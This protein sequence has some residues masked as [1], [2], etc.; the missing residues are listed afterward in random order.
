MLS[1]PDFVEKQVI[2][3]ESNNTNK[4]KLKNS[5]LVVLG[6]ENKTILQHPLSKIFLVFIC[7][8]FSITSVLLRNARR[9]GIKIVFLNHSLR[10]YF[11]VSQQNIGNFLLR[12]KQYHNDKELDM[13]KFV[14]KNK[15]L[16]QRALMNSLRYKTQKEK[17]SIR[18]MNYLL[19]DISTARDSSE[20]LGIEGAAAKLYF[21][22]YFKN[23]GFKKRTPRTKTDI[24]NLLLDVGY[25]YLFNFIDANLEIYGF[26][27][28]CGFYHKFFFQ[29]KSLVCDLVE[30]FRCIID[31]RVRKSFNLKQI[32]KNDFGFGNGQYFIKRSF[33]KKYSR[34]F[35]KEILKFKEEIFLFIQSFYRNFMK[36]HSV[37][38]FPMFLVGG[39]K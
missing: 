13:A 23:M 33:N 1:R 34:L 18:R 17:G 6:E 15:L 27:T 12:K 11:S 24:I 10:P 35:L 14:V 31:R 29:R 38:E 9:Y 25:Y 16:N 8:E 21:S 22:T 20:L 32:N 2:F 28:Y 26:D 19:E 39:K 4:I 5:N 7:G 30:P 37:S 3:I 36:G